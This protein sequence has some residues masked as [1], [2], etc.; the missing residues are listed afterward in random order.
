MISRRIMRAAILVLSVTVLMPMMRPADARSPDPAKIDQLLLRAQHLADTVEIKRLQC[1]YGYYLD[2]SDWDAV[3]DLFTDDIV[4]EYGNS[5]VFRGKEH[6]RALLYA[7][8][9]GKSGLRV[10]QLR[11]HIQLEPVVD[12]APDGQSARGRWKALVLLG[13]YGEYARWQTGP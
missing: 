11:D 3:L 2:R 10:G 13:Q 1:E 7:I 4:A 6:V 12:V 8:G 9:Y 5:G